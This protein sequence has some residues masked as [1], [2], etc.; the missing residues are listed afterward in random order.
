MIDFKNMLKITLSFS[1][2]KERL[3]NIQYLLITEMLR[4]KGDLLIMLKYN[5]LK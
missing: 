3:K 1:I 5:T 2:T 4:N